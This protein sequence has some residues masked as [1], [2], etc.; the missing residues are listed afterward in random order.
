MFIIMTLI[1]TCI[2]SDEW[3]AITPSFGTTLNSRG[4]DGKVSCFV[5]GALIKSWWVM[6]GSVPSFVIPILKVT[7]TNESLCSVTCFFAV[8]PVNAYQLHIIGILDRENVYG[9]FKFCYLQIPAL[10]CL[11]RPFRN[12]DWSYQSRVLERRCI[13]W[14]AVSLIT[15]IGHHIYIYIRNIL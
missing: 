6:S 8:K 2:W 12:R 7:G 10:T 4:E 15:Y 9:E 13:P 11:K 5:E 14:R 3:A 1:L